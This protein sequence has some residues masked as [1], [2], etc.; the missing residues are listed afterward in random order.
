MVLCWR[1]EVIIS[2][3]LVVRHLF[4]K[5]KIVEVSPFPT[6]SY[7]TIRM[8]YYQIWKGLI[9]KI[10]SDHSLVT[11]LISISMCPKEL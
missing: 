11:K 6:A 10:S 2:T 7:R 1:S 4:S 9:S 8:L 5:V 3:E